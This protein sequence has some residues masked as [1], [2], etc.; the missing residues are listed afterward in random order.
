MPDWRSFWPR[1]WKGQSWRGKGFTL[2][3]R[4]KGYFFFLAI[5]FGFFLA[6]N[7]FTLIFGYGA[8]DDY[9]L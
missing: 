3:L 4:W 7:C 5:F 2:F 8:F 9:G 6:F 1:N